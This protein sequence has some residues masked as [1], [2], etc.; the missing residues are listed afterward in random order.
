MTQPEEAPR[1]KRFR[2]RIPLPPAPESPIVIP[3]ETREVANGLLAEINDA[4]NDGRRYEALYDWFHIAPEMR[5]TIVDATLLQ[6]AKP[7]E[8][9]KSAQ[10]RTKGTP[11]NF[12]LSH[13][14]LLTSE[15]AGKIIDP[16][17]EYMVTDD[18]AHKL[19]QNPA[20][21]DREFSMRI[22]GLGLANQPSETPYYHDYADFQEP[23]MDIMRSFSLEDER[24][25]LVNL[26]PHIDA[27][28]SNQLLSSVG[29][30]NIIQH[31]D[32]LLDPRLADRLE[33]ALVGK[34]PWELYLANYLSQGFFPSAEFFEEAFKRLPP[35]LSDPNAVFSVDANGG[36]DKTDIPAS[37]FYFSMLQKITGVKGLRKHGSE[38]GREV[39]ITEYLLNDAF[40]QHALPYLSIDQ[41][42]REEFI[43]ELSTIFYGE[44]VAAG[45]EAKQIKSQRFSEILK[46]AIGFLEEKGDT[47]TIKKLKD[48]EV[49]GIKFS[50]YL[51]D[52]APSVESLSEI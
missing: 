35:E 17:E 12:V 1:R 34:M 48:R 7:K 37:V 11:S 47:D 5:T 16:Q 42:Y 22:R 24:Q 20:E 51:G 33:K 28:D 29:I 3:A 9:L 41:A 27:E 14:A 43:H 13:Y 52:S 23:N 25:L 39:K 31:A 36:R 50:D 40:M 19:R 8:S 18:D 45:D 15:A 32:L 21:R 10:D 44:V 6:E 38:Q 30:V 26:L 2:E 4:W 46:E 49:A